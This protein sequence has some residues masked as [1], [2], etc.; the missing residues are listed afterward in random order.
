MLMMAR[1]AEPDR[2]T[3]AWADLSDTQRTIARL[4]SQAMTNQQIAHR[5]RLS[6]HTVNY[7]LRQIFRKL[8]I[9][10][11]VELAGIARERLTERGADGTGGAPAARS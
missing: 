2:G 4:V 8:G 10:S 3:A 6:P 11:R 9:G 5:V 1:M 7:H